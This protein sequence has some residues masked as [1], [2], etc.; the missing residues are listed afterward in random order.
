MLKNR[1]VLVVSVL[2]VITLLLI[3]P[4]HAINCN[5]ILTQGAYDMLQD[6][7]NIVRIAVPI[8]LIVFGSIDFGGAVINDD[9]DGLKKASGKF[10]KRCLCA[11]AIFFVP[12]IV[13]TIL[14][15]PGIK[16]NVTL[17]DDPLCGIE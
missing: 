6:A 1:I 17:V 12:L 15:M 10:I 8:L 5:G 16:D 9:K 2:I 4:V 7:I 3:E 14:S 11:V 13:R